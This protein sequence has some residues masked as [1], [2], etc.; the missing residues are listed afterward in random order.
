M[1]SVQTSL[2]T[3]LRNG[4]EFTDV[5]R[6]VIVE[7]AKQRCHNN[8]LELY[9]D[10]QAVEEIGPTL[11][12][13]RIGR[14]AS[15][16]NRALNFSSNMTLGTLALIAAALGRD[17]K[18]SFPEFEAKRN[19]EGITSKVGILE[20]TKNKKPFQR[21]V[22]HA[23]FVSASSDQFNRKAKGD[24]RTKQPYRIKEDA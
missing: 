24:I 9:R 10:K 13:R 11:I 12:G 23:V 6:V 16:V 3:K 5:E 8:L 14:H 1:T 7:R 15:R 21:K 17:M 4:G 2:S 18:V 20:I 19:Y 22:S